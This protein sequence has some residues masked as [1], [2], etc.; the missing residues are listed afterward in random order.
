MWKLELKQVEF[1]LQL[2]A[3]E[4]VV[5]DSIKSLYQNI[6]QLIE[7]DYKKPHFVI[8]FGIQNLMR[9][10]LAIKKEVDALNVSKPFIV[11]FNN[12]KK[13]HF[14]QRLIIQ[15]TKWVF[16]KKNISKS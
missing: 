1:Y 15:N 16:I 8:G 5:P 12:R 9:K 2:G 4:Q 13:F 7:L 3:F 6:P 14:K 10:L 11:A